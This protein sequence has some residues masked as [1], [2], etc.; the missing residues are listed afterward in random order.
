MFAAVGLLVIHVVTGY[1]VQVPVS[2]PICIGQQNTGPGG[3]FGYSV[4]L[5]SGEGDIS[6]LVS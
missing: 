5:S 6:W 3:M 2:E 4:A 1:V